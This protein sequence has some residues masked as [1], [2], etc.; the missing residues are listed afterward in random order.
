M[1][2]N[3]IVTNELKLGNLANILYGVK[4]CEY[5]K[6]CEKIGPLLKERLKNNAGFGYQ[7]C[8]IEFIKDHFWPELV[9]KYESTLKRQLVYDIYGRPQNSRSNNGGG[10][11]FQND[12]IQYIKNDCIDAMVTQIKDR[13]SQMEY[14]QFADGIQKYLERI[15]KAEQ[16]EKIR[17]N[18]IDK[19]L[20]DNYICYIKKILND[21]E[22]EEDCYARTI[23]W[24]IIGCVLR[25]KMSEIQNKFISDGKNDIQ[26]EIS[27][28]DSLY[29]N[30]ASIRVDSC[31]GKKIDALYYSKEYKYSGFYY[32]NS[33]F[34]CY[35]REREFALIDD[36]I[37]RDETVLWLAVTGKAGVGKSKLLYSYIKSKPRR[38]DIGKWVSILVDAKKVVDFLDCDAWNYPAN[39][40]IVF[41]YAGEAAREIGKWI[42]KLSA[43]NICKRIRIVLLE[44]E[45]IK[46][47]NEGAA[48]LWYV[49]L[50]GTHDQ[51][52]RIEEL[53]YDIGS[54][55]K[56]LHL[57][58]VGV[59]SGTDIIRDY[60]LN[61][62]REQY[63]SYDCN[64]IYQAAQDIDSFD[65]YPRPAILLFTVDAFIKK[66]D[67][68]KWD[69]DL[70]TE[71]IEDK[72]LRYIHDEV[73]SECESREY[74]EM[75]KLLLYS[76]CTGR[77][78]IETEERMNPYF[79]GAQSMFMD[80]PDARKEQILQVMNTGN[81]SPFFL[82]PLE[83]DLI[84]EKFVLDSFLKLNAQERIGAIADDMLKRYP[85]SFSRC[86]MRCISDYYYIERYRVLFENAMRKWNIDLNSLPIESKKAWIQ[87]LLH[88]SFCADDAVVRG[89]CKKVI[90]FI[91]SVGLIAESILGIDS[92][93]ISVKDYL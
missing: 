9:K 30:V 56:T 24:L 4:N 89:E 44:R 81:Q 77:L 76:T 46:R 21:K 86:L 39:L 70:L 72:V 40:L 87:V 43:D 29:N 36:F 47:E 74:D 60:I 42:Y 82:Y 27:K 19:D 78:R 57:F 63:D 92:D 13:L 45:G 93:T 52:R 55:Y 20:L 37:M 53:R 62:D 65:K 6:G 10:V 85:R 38:Q 28:E 8:S 14:T 18:K 23:A 48:P 33:E 5:E 90:D 88:L 3:R 54:E 35:G 59:E 26:K 79:V 68:K 64:K 17:E 75:I 31:F 71:Y 73:F 34:V 32:K 1:A 15:P 11:G 41:D 58:G 80:F 84:A 69:F 91:G 25:N 7:K 16:G 83:P 66:G 22:N 51:K 2:K 50:Q 61:H 12:V 67:S 49:E